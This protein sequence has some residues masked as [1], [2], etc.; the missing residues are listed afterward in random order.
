MWRWLAWLL[1][2]RVVK[3]ASDAPEETLNEIAALALQ[4]C[5]GIATL[6]DPVPVET[7]LTVTRPRAD[8]AA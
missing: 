1:Q 8:Q 7:A 4:G 5:P 6:R 2:W 3:E